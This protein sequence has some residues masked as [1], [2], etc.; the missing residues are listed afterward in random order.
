MRMFMAALV[1]VSVVVG[2]ACS[3]PA[4]PTGLGIPE[5]PQLPEIGAEAEAALPYDAQFIDALIAYATYT[6]DLANVGVKRAQKQELKVY[7]ENLR[8]QQ[9]VRIAELENWRTLW[10]GKAK[11]KTANLKQ[12]AENLGVPPYQFGVAWKTVAIELD[13]KHPETVKDIA[14]AEGV[15]QWGADEQ[16]AALKEVP[17]AAF[18]AFYTA[19]LVQHDIWGMETAHAALPRLEHAELQTVGQEV[20][21]ENYIRLNQVAR[22]RADWFGA[23][24]EGM[25]PEEPGTR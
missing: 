10:Y 20:V 1:V 6:K 11:S 22:W 2:P 8:E 25:A 15:D 24:T 14:V 16:L 18:D 5:P 13:P 3:R 9:A 21:T 23:A 7:A 17:D 12:A 19:T 4:A